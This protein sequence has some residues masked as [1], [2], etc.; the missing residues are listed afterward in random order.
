M[1]RDSAAESHDSAVGGTEIPVD[2][3]GRLPR[4]YTGKPAATVIPEHVCRRVN[5]GAGLQCGCSDGICAR[6]AVDRQVNSKGSPNLEAH[7]EL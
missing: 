7:W 1:E 3:R 5:G 2:D 4:N 6:S